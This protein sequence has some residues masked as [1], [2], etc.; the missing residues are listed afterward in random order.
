MRLNPITLAGSVSIRS[1]VRQIK[2]Q[3]REPNS[4]SER[5]FD[6]FASWYH[7]RP[8][9]RAHTGADGGEMGSIASNSFGPLFQ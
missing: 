1:S 4:G 8:K 6:L 7:E 3:Y 2:L 9:C 5:G